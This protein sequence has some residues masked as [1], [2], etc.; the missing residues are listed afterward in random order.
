MYH[1]TIWL[2][3]GLSAG[4]ITRR[5][6][7]G[8]P[9]YGILGDLTT[10]CLGA[11]VGGWLMRKTGVLAPDNLL[12]HVFTA[13]VGAT[14]L[15]TLIRWL[16]H[17]LPTV[18]RLSTGQSK[19]QIPDWEAWVRQSTDFERGLVARLLGRDS[20]RADPNQVFDT[21]LTFGQR[22]ADKVASFGGSWTFIGLFFISMI[23]WMVLNEDLSKP[24]D[25]FPFIR[26]KF[27]L[28][29]P[30]RHSSANHHD[31]SESTVRAGSHRRAQRLRSEFARGTRN[32]GAPCE[33][34]CGTRRG[35]DPASRATQSPGG[36]A[37]TARGTRGRGGWKLTIT[38]KTER[39][40]VRKKT[41]ATGEI[42]G[43]RI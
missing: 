23:S 9:Q 41:R 27:D 30:C 16:W 31:E 20:S 12:G 38:P 3:I 32:H 7:R 40:E 2:A 14:I 1:L 13:M 6:V 17:A 29:V 37:P 4:W 15:L 10:G 33:T 11:V 39:T 28:V 22:I 43:R 24:F 35:I 18:S 34:R 8:D 21:Q 26:L 19:L 25:P 5:A 36:P 42:N